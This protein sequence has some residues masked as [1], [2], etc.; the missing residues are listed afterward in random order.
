MIWSLATPKEQALAHLWLE[1][2]VDRSLC[3]GP[4][5]A[6]PYG[7]SWM[8]IAD[9][10]VDRLDKHYGFVPISEYS[11]RVAVPSKYMA[12]VI[13]TELKAMISP[14]LEVKAWMRKLTKKLLPKG[15]PLEWTTPMGWPMRIADR[16][17]TTQKV[18]TQSVW[19]Q[20][21]LQHPRPAVGVSA[22]RHASEQ[23]DRGESHPLL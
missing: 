8:S 7:G 5:L 15:Y 10:L 19:H 13:W 4:V 14:V 17:P 6:A 2:G 3:K 18:I 16:Q 20:D 12:S 21:Q 1:H 9:G 23:G 11:Y 22:E